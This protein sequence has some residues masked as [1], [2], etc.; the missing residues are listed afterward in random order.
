MA[1]TFSAK[2]KELEQE[3]SK[4]DINFLKNQKE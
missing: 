2:I 1:K 4:F 3:K